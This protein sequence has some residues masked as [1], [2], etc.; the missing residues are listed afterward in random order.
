MCA[1]GAAWQAIGTQAPPEAY[2]K[3][4]YYDTI[5]HYGA[6]R[7]LYTDYPE[8]RHGH[9]TTVVTRKGKSHGHAPKHQRRHG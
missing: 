3:Q 5:C 8:D 1:S 6:Q 9:A 2:L 4:L 7:H